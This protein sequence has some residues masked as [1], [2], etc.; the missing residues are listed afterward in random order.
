MMGTPNASVRPD[1]CR[2]S[3]TIARS[4]CAKPRQTSETEV[5]HSRCLGEAMDPS[6]GF[7]LAAVTLFGLTAL[8]RGEGPWTTAFSLRS[9]VPAHQDEQKEVRCVVGPLLHARAKKV[10]VAPPNP[11]D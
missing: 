1:R 5:W 7:V 6:K 11:V 8:A 10:E 9:R 2:C 3:R 4:S